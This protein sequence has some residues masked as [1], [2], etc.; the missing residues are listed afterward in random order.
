MARAPSDG[1][2]VPLAMWIRPT[3]PSS[4]AVQPIEARIV[5]VLRSGWRRNRQAS[6]SPS[7]GSTQASEPNPPTATD[8]MDRPAAL[9]IRNHRPAAS[10]MAAPRVS[11]PTPSRLWWGSRSRAPRPMARAANPTAPATPSQAAAIIRPVHVTRSTT[12]SRGLRAGGR[13][14]FVDLGRSTLRPWAAGFRLLFFFG[15]ERVW[16]PCPCLRR[17]AGRAGDLTAVEPA[18]SAGQPRPARRS[19]GQSRYGHGSPYLQ[20]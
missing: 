5:S 10:T 13:R 20:T 8:R 7:T 14:P 16:L 17:G 11:S 6:S 12:G 18:A 2:G 9:G 1:R 3:A 4:S 19:S 15:A